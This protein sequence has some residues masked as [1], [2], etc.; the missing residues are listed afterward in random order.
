MN[1]RYILIAIVVVVGVGGVFFAWKYFGAPKEVKV[2]E[3]I[4]KDVT[5]DWILYKNDNPSFSIK[6]PSNFKQVEFGAIAKFREYAKDAKGGFIQ[7][8]EER[9]VK[10]QI[11]VVVSPV[12]GEYVEKIAESIVDM[13]N[14]AIGNPVESELG[15]SKKTKNVDLPGCSAV[16]ISVVV[17][18]NEGAFTA[19]LYEEG[20]S[21]YHLSFNLSAKEGVLSEYIEEYEVMLATFAIGWQTYRNEKWGFEMKYPGQWVIKEIGDGFFEI[22]IKQAGVSDIGSIVF[23]RDSNI[24]TAIQ[25]HLTK[26]VV[27]TLIQREE[28]ISLDGKDGKLVYQNTGGRDL[29]E[30][31][32]SKW[33]FV[34]NNGQILKLGLYFRPKGYDYDELFDLMLSTFRFIK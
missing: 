13:R 11:E 2:L 6:I 9:W 24:N 1:A 16:W 18:P 14:T 8:E 33:Y 22:H 10:A 25:N 12:G 26:Y 17:S 15:T 5:A 30:D 27:G 4:V 23:T 21:T 28:N 7:D 32:L 29:Q 31:D 3:E 20:N 34:V 19:C